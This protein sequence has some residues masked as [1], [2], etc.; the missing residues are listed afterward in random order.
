MRVESLIRRPAG[1]VV[2]LDGEVYAFQPPTW[3]TEVQTPA[4]VARFG[5]IPEGYRL[6]PAPLDLT[7]PPSPAAVTAARPGPRR[8]GR[9]RPAAVTTAEIL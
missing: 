7:A 4:H 5:A 3:A 6:V 2:T 8:R 9:P 1:H